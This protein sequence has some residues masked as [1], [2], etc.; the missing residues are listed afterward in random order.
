M[1]NHEEI[2]QK[3]EAILNDSDTKDYFIDTQSM[4]Q[5]TTMNQVGEVFIKELNKG[6]MEEEEY[7]KNRMS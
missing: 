2:K 1:T 3:I 7:K 4:K 5:E 6:G